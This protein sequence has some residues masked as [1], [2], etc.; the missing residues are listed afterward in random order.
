MRT[1]RGIIES[2]SQ[3]A[4]FWSGTI[5]ILNGPNA[6]AYPEYRGARGSGMRTAFEPS[7]RAEK[8]KGNHPGPAAPEGSPRHSDRRDPAAHVP[9]YAAFGEGAALC[10]G[11]RRAASAA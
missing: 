11:A 1:S 9:C 8:E 7:R 3:V 5:S 10:A 4:E 6:D 2:V